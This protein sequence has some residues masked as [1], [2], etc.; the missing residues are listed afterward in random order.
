M[1]SRIDILECFKCGVTSERNNRIAL[2][3]KQIA[4]HCIEVISFYFYI[5]RKITKKWNVHL[6]LISEQEVFFW[7]A[8]GWSNYLTFCNVYHF[9]VFPLLLEL[10]RKIRLLPIV[11]SSIILKTILWWVKSMHKTNVHVLKLKMTP[12]PYV[13][14]KT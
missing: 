6:M 13:Y 3:F 2:N 14:G 7:L 9:L 8:T 11:Y 1:V 12:V 10:Y 4:V 5:W